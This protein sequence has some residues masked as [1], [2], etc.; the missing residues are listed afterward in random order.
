MQGF[1][2]AE[3]LEIRTNTVVEK[4]INALVKLASEIIS[5]TG[6]P[7]E[8]TI[9]EFLLVGYS[10]AAFA[11]LIAIVTMTTLTNYIHHNGKFDIDFP[12]AQS[13][14]NKHVA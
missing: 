12:L 6:F 9:N 14:N 7:S 3:T 10:K 8:R 1:S 5:K 2:E 11:E 4:K 13:L